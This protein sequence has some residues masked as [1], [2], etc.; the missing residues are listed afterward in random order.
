[1]CGQ[2]IETWHNKQCYCS[3]ACRRAAEKDRRRLRHSK[4]VKCPLCKGIYKLHEVW[5]GRS[6]NVPTG[7]FLW[8][9]DAVTT[10]SSG[11]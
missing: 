3:D 2:R 8:V 6:E 5:R 1:M 10:D 7:D 11:L 9:N 4:L